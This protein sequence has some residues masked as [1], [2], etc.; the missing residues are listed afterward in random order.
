MRIETIVMK[1]WFSMSHSDRVV[2][3]ISGS[4]PHQF[5]IRCAVRNVH[6]KY[7]NAELP[8]PLYVQHPKIHVLETRWPASCSHIPVALIPWNCSVHL[9]Y[10]TKR[11][12]KPH[13]FA[14]KAKVRLLREHRAACRYTAAT[15]F[16][17][18][19]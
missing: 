9:K 5:I 17:H 6:A 15:Y 3:S 8:K 1:L 12:N 14:N 2:I 11:R 18:G 16:I 7:R 19:R 13:R 10:R 4:K